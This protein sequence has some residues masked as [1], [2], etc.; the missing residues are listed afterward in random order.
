MTVP[1]GG[2]KLA[3]LQRKGGFLFAER[4]LRQN[5]TVAIFERSTHLFAMERSAHSSIARVKVTLRNRCHVSRDHRK[6]LLRDLEAHGSSPFR[7]VSSAWPTWPAPTRSWT[8]LPAEHDAPAQPY[9]PF[10]GSSARLPFP[11]STAREGIGSVS[12]SFFSHPHLCEP[13]DTLTRDAP[14]SRNS[15]IVKDWF[16][17]GP[18]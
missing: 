11:R 4:W 10:C 15:A 3:P 14:G 16:N 8:F 18:R 6:D 5:G 9:P 1:L 17:P 12:P 2:R 7:R 13:N